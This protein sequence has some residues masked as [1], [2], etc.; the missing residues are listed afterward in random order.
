VATLVSENQQAR[1]YQLTWDA[2]GLASGLFFY[3][4]EAGW[5][6]EAKRMLLLK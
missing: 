5:F 2:G 3:R 4:L 6:Q 1:H